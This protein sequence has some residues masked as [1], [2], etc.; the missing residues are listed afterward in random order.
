[1]AHTKS[2]IE[3]NIGI[4][5]NAHKRS[6]YQ[7]IR[8]YCSPV[9]TDRRT[10]GSIENKSGTSEEIRFEAYALLMSLIERTRLRLRRVVSMGDSLAT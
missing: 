5:I 1:M 9:Y 8:A 6:A 2:A 7:V 4:I 10:P 3:L